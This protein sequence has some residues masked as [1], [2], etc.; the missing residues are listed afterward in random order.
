ML[1]RDR[2]EAGRLLGAYLKERL[3]RREQGAVVLGIPRGGARVAPRGDRR[4]AGGAAGGRAGVRR[5]RR[6]ARGA[7]DAVPLRRGGPLLRRLP[8]DRGRRGEG[9]PPCPPRRLAFTVGTTNLSM[10]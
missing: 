1:F 3:P 10:H 7:R 6:A 8:P 2:E 4:G 9:G 5:R